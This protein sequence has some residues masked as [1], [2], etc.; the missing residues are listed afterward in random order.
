LYRYI[1]ADEN[2]KVTG[3]RMV[4]LR[5]ETISS[6]NSYGCE[7]AFSAFGKS[8]CGDL[9]RITI[10]D[11]DKAG[12]QIGDVPPQDASLL[13]LYTPS[14]G[15]R[16]A[17]IM[18]GS[19]FG[20]NGSYSFGMTLRAEPDRSVIVRPVVTD[21][22]SGE[23]VTD[24]ITMSPLSVTFQPTQWNTPQLVQIMANSDNT[25][26]GKKNYAVTWVMQS[27]DSN[28][29]NGAET[30]AA[31]NV[32][33]EDADR[34]DVILTRLTTFERFSETG[35]P[36]RYS[37]KLSS[38]PTA[39][40]TLTIV[41]RISTNAAKYGAN[42][43]AV[44]YTMRP[45]LAAQSPAV[46]SFIRITPPSITIVGSSS[47]SFTFEVGFD[48]GSVDGQKTGD[49]PIELFVKA[50]TQDL[51]YNGT[52]AIRYLVAGDE[53]AIGFITENTDS[54][55][56]E[57][58]TDVR[59]GAKL[60][61][62]PL[63]AVR[64]T[65][66]APVE[67]AR[68]PNRRCSTMNNTNDKVCDMDGGT[69]WWGPCGIDA[70]EAKCKNHTTLV[71]GESENNFACTHFAH[72]AKDNECYLF[73]SCLNETDHADYDLFNINRTMQIIVK[74]ATHPDTRAD[75]SGGMDLI[76]TPDNWNVFQAGGPDADWPV[77]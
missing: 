43:S 2:N 70:C 16:N 14:P 73:A 72:N 49:V 20:T 6:L 51:Q 40:V 71:P 3:D 37:I 63:S 74:N 46:D 36:V 17:T 13:S 25:V 66:E 59:I 64:L 69:K 8:V 44:N 23:I 19:S 15:A 62:K 21:L 28:F 22:S 55:L 9:F 47:D 33:V 54:L 52:S 35:E 56:E 67:R 29:N 68:T 10:R 75:K 61:S 53:D 41:P 18:E 60:A 45:T 1:A 32:E 31:V 48:S 42:N 50:V 57:N 11:N 30:A 34:A 7:G 76:F 65:V 39:N 12:V 58:G 27:A 5:L 77:K 26:E 24:Q 4:E 38:L